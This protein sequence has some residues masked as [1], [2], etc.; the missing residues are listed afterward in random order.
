[1]HE[2]GRLICRLLVQRFG[3]LLARAEVLLA[4][5]GGELVHVVARDAMLAPMP[6]EG[7]VLGAVGVPGDGPCAQDEK[8]LF[9]FNVIVVKDRRACLVVGELVQPRFVLLLHGDLIYILI[10][11]FDHSLVSF[12]LLV[13]L[14]CHLP[15]SSWEGLTSKNRWFHSET[16][17]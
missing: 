1:M 5:L 17:L 9:V 14:L 2:L 4:T 7:C 6:H 15:L 8:C 3:W 13:A 11:L 16:S 12:S 10:H